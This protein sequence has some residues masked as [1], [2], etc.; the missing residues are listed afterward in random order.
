MPSG[1]RCALAEHAGRLDG[2]DRWG[3]VLRVTGELAARVAREVA[4]KCY[5]ET[6]T[7]LR[8]LGVVCRRLLEHRQFAGVLGGHG[9]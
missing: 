9:Y 3:R 1:L 8:A 6:G 4:G 2:R 5:G 7:P